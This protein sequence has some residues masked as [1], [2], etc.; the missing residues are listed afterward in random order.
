[1]KRSISFWEEKLEKA[2]LEVREL[3]M[4]GASR[5]PFPKRKAHPRGFWFQRR[6]KA[7]QSLGL[8]RK[9]RLRLTMLEQT[10]I[11]YYTAQIEKLKSRNFWQHLLSS[12]FGDDL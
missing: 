7:L 3:R 6:E 11:P 1:M 2:V 9:R 4:L 12:N 8:L 10:K 5:A